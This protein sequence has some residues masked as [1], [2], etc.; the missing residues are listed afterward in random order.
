MDLKDTLILVFLNVNCIA[1]NKT[2]YFGGI[3]TE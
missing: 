1:L 2:V 3:M